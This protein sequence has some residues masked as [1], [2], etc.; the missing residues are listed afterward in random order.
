MTQNDP[1]APSIRQSLSLDGAWRIAFDK[2]NQGREA[3]WHILASF[4]ELPDARSIVVPSCWE[5]VEQD[6]EGVAYYQRSFEIPECWKGKMVSLQ[7]DA[8]NYRTEVWLNGS[9]LGCHEGGY[10]PFSFRVDEAFREEKTQELR[11]RVLGPLISGTKVIDGLGQN[12]MPH[13]RGAITGG[14]WQSVR[15]IA[16]G[17]SQVEDVFVIPSL[18]KNA[19]EL[20]CAIRELGTQGREVT[21]TLTVA[22]NA[23]PH[24]P[25]A[26]HKETVELKPGS[27]ALD[28][29]LDVPDVQ[30]WD[31]ENPHLYIARVEVEEG[32]YRH[33]SVA[34]R[35]GFRE[36]TIRNHQL[37]LNGKAIY[38]KAAFFEGL[39]PNGLALPDNE[40]MARREIELARDAGFN[41]IRP[42]RKPPPPAWL[43]LCDEM[44]MMVVGGLPIECMDRWPTVTP[45]L[46][47][48]IEH[49][50]RAAILRDRNRTCIVQWELFNEIWRP[51]LARLKHPMAMLARELDPSRLILD[52]SGGFSGGA[53]IYL[54]GETVP[55][56]FNDVHAYPGAP[57]SDSSYEWFLTLAKTDDELKAMGLNPDDHKHDHT[58]PGRLTFVS[59]IG[60]GSLPNLP[61]NNQTF[62]QSGNPLLPPYRY[63]RELETSYRKVLSESGLDAIY[64]D[65][66]SFCVEQQKRH[67][68]ANRRMI[69]SIR[70]NPRI[71]G[72]AVHALTDGDWVLGAGLL[73][74]F[75]EPKEVYWSTKIA[76]QPRHLVLRT[77]ARN[78]YEEDGIELL[79]T[80]INDLEAV[81]GDVQLKICTSSGETVWDVS[82]SLTLAQG[83][84]ELRK[85]KIT[86]LTVGEYRAHAIFSGDRTFIEVETDFRIFASEIPKLKQAH[87]SVLDPNGS[88]IIF[89]DENAIP[90]DSFHPEQS[91]ELPVYVSMPRE[92]SPEVLEVFQ[93]LHDFVN[94]GGTAVYLETILRP[95]GNPYWAADLPAK[96]LLPLELEKQHALG[97]WVG[98]SHCV[99]EHPVFADL[100]VNQSM[101]Q[102][103]EN[104][105]GPHSLEIEGGDRIVSS[106]SH[107]YYQDQT[108]DQHYMG[109]QDAWVGMDLGVVS[110]GSG[111]YV[112]S[113]LRL[114]ENLGK[115]PV[116]DKIVSNLIQWV[117]TLY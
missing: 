57:F 3:G 18:E 89:L 104:V 66:E 42:W 31:A 99:E 102:L 46:P 21:V 34:E 28:W 77:M 110:S 72:Y 13:W 48:R 5:E 58:T 86:Q 15:L 23:S 117:S 70:C 7:F 96:E 26:T 62:S 29:T 55:E 14:I 56:K 71:R 85:E 25:V 65:I 12:D 78:A 105:W 50:V 73:D 39:Y 108:Q 54:P 20:K 53:N 40:A 35:F 60:Y 106:V 93:A 61:A 76:N 30:L 64:P 101:G 79:L 82:Q 68:D 81:S 109:P 84:S 47:G 97:L 67:G 111:R 91:K 38:I 10:G 43:D 2:E 49:E 44:G 63:H 51:E 94:A 37:E 22:K 16:T 90:Y 100:P 11:L 75:R 113:T 27:N 87:F 4:P 98:V 107:N 45:Q 112:L 36:V 69:E 8:V 80:G 6:Y 95:E 74:L 92:A 1:H 19:V 41:M 9:A 116:A 52:E 115:D 33:D 88:L 59:E 32:E 114:L 24:S 17:Q 83:V 103:Y